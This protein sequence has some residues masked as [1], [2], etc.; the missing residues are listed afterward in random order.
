[1]ERF[2]IRR[3][4]ALPL[5]LK[6]LL[7]SSLLIPFGSFMVLPFI[8]IL[9]HTQAGMNMRLVGIILGIASFIQFSGGFVGGIV[10]EKFGLKR[11]MIGALAIRSLGFWVLALSYKAPFLIVLALFLITTG[12]A[13]YLP[14]N[15]AYLVSAAPPDKKALF[16]SFSNSALN[17][18]MALGP[19]VG[20]ALIMHFTTVLFMAVFL[21]FLLLTIVHCVYIS[22][23]NDRKKP[24]SNSTSRLTTYHFSVTFCPL[25]YNALA[26]YSYFFFQ[27]YM[28]PYTSALY[29][30]Q[31]YSFILALNALLIV[32]LQPLLSGWI[33][34]C[35]YGTLLSL[36]F[37][38]MAMSMLLFSVGAL[39][40]L[41]LGTLLITFSEILLF[42]KN[43]LEILERLPNRPAIAFGLQRL[44]SGMGALSSGILGGLLFSRT[45]QNNAPHFFW[46]FLAAQSVVI[47]LCAL[48]YQLP[49]CLEQEICRFDNLKHSPI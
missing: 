33:K 23:N 13:L 11:T 10:A 28:G 6:A 8:P 16:L 2:G 5:A 4:N 42:L 17:A 37:A 15:K 48:H 38:L 12:A 35:P 31:T 24:K 25:I 7:I 19:L 29:S 21:S 26:F 47:A 36:S 46:I 39:T 20:G 9:L 45:S 14:A 41:F 49:I 44:S 34:K 3:F 1:M 27:N 40:A 32:F 18:G 30:T 43:D 22:E